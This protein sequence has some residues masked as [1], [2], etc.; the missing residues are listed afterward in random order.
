[1]GLIKK[2]GIKGGKLLLEG[3]SL[4]NAA[5]GTS[6]PHS[7]A[8]RFGSAAAHGS[9]APSEVLPVGTVLQKRYAVEAVLGAGGMSV[10]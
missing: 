3:T 6:T 5:S 4:A 9:T 8:A 10:V 1:M 7:G 2:G